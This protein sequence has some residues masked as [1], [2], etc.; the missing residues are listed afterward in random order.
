VARPA[1]DLRRRIVLTGALSVEQRER[2]LQIANAWPIH[3]A[4]TGE[5]RIAT[6]LAESAP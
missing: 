2:L 1:S 6:T 3:E 4:L 5:I